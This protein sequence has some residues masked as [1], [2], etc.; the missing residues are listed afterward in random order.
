[1]GKLPIHNFSISVDGYGAGPDQSC[2]D[3][4]VVAKILESAKETS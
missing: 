2:V 3:H 4:I 1:M